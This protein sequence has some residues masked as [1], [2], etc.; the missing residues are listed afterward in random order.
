MRKILG[1]NLGDNLYRMY[2]FFCGRS[3][4]KR[5]LASIEKRRLVITT[6]LKL[7]NNNNA[8]LGTTTMRVRSKRLFKSIFFDG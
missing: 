5:R 1:S 3:I 8:K 2:V 7:G 4:E 6:K